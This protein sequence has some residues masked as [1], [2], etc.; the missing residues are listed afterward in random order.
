MQVEHFLPSR[1][2]LLK[3]C[4]RRTH[5]F[6]QADHCPQLLLFKK[7]SGRPF[8]LPLLKPSGIPA[9]RAL[10]GLGTQLAELGA[11]KHAHG[12]HAHQHHHHD[13][14]LLLHLAFLLVPE[15]LLWTFGIVT[16]QP[17]LVKGFCIISAH[18]PKIRHIQSR[19]LGNYSRPSSGC[20]TSIPV[21][22]PSGKSSWIT[23]CARFMK[24]AT[25]LPFACASA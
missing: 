1:D 14:A 2:H 13:G 20:C 5:S 24:H 8:D 17:P 23:L 16:R 19:S 3:C 11:T 21:P 18:S 9:Y 7:N 25:P 6:A 12:A 10:T 22:G 15:Y 4:V